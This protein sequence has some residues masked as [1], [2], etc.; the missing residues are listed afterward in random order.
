MRMLEGIHSSNVVTCCSLYIH[1]KKQ[2]IEFFLPALCVAALYFIKLD[3]QSDPNSSLK[4]VTVPA[5]YPD[6]NSVIIPLSFQDYVTALQAKR[7]CI[8]DPS[9]DAFEK[10]FGLASL[11]ISGIDYETWPVPF[12]FCQSYNC[13]E[14]GEDATKYCTYR[15]LALAPMNEGST[16]EVQRL[17]RFKQYV[18]TRYPQLTNSSLLPFEYD[19]IQIF[20]SND[21]LQSYVTSEQYGE[22]S[23]DDGSTYYP[24]GE[25]A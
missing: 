19:F 17:L 5:S 24:K 15:T 7:V 6:A 14:R 8:V 13:K 12:V 16:G 10:I 11:V 21:D 2:L 20:D 25:N 23:D 18:E 9:A 4:A 22:W 3:L 1:I